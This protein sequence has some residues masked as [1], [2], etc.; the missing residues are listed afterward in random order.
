MKPR[1]LILGLLFSALAGIGFVGMGWQGEEQKAEGSSFVETVRELLPIAEIR[2]GIPM[3]L[4]IPAVDL[5]ANI[6]QVG[7]TKTGAMA[8]PSDWWTTG[9][10]KYGSR[11]G[12]IGSAVIAGHLDTETAEA[13][14]WDLQKLKAGDAIEVIDEHETVRTFIVERIAEYDEDKAPLQEL[15]ASNDAARLN[16]ITCAGNWKKNSGEY[17]KRLVVYAKLQ[18]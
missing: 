2:P 6:E 9:W 18:P 16:L 17:D 13:V 3:K 5:E 4:R 15:F 12:E 14:F 1:I 8:N 7:K 11:P 10:Y